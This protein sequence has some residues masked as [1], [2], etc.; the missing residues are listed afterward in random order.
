MGSLRAK[1]LN[2]KMA[3]QGLSRGTNRSDMQLATA[4]GD[5]ECYIERKLNEIEG[6]LVHKDPES[7]NLLNGIMTQLD[8]AQKDQKGELYSM[9]DDLKQAMV[10]VR[11]IGRTAGG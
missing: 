3:K 10:R 4:L 9:N 1:Q 5:Y 11:T 2:L 8:H 7:Q 6:L